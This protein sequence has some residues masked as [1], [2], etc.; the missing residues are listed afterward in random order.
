M[1]GHLTKRSNGSWSI[2]IDL[3]RDPAGK[4]KQAWRTVR[5]T[6]KQAQ[7]ELTRLLHQMQTGVHVEAH[8]LTV[9][10]YLERWLQ[11]YAK[12][13]LA[14]KTYLRYAVI[15]RGHLIPALG[16]YPLVKVS[17]LHIEECFAKTRER[18]RLDGKGALSE[19]TLLHHHR[20]L[21]LAMKTAVKWRLMV[22]NPADA[23]EAPRPDR[24][25]MR[26]LDERETVK[27]LD[28]AKGTRLYVPLL[29]TVTTG[30]RRGELLALRWQDVDLTRGVLTVRQTLE[31]TPGC[32]RFK[33]PKT[34]KSTRSISLL[35]LTI[36]A[37]RT[38]EIAQKK[39]RLMI[40][41]AYE[42]NG[43]VFPRDD[44]AVWPPNGLTGL[45]F[46]LVKKAN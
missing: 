2:V 15:C 20:V 5:G 16:N 41:P 11:A 8:R 35:T 18:G 39:L 24:H 31:Q 14:A 9:H 7:E 27:L 34:R 45:Y 22:R 26:A 3:G 6:K 43:L 23:V 4:R 38:H 25:E 19:Q 30:L 21:K 33:K 42:D 12:P 37:L 46:K 17:P 44:G 10:E 28:A 13:N 36:E 40:G 29:V 1:K 32:L